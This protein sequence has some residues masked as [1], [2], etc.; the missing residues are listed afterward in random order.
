M[1]N[2][3]LIGL[4][5]S[6]GI[7]LGSTQEGY[8]WTFEDAVSSTV[9]PIGKICEL[10]A[11]EE[12]IGQAQCAMSSLMTS[13]GVTS[14]LLKEIQEVQPDAIA[15]V[16]GEEVTPSLL[17]VVERIQTEIAPEKSFEEIIELISSL[18]L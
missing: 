2:N 17:S 9:A 15:F 4:F 3:F 11:T 14:A 13:T 7:L 18:D 10:F 1:R 8:A 6:F 16:A 12:G 5:L